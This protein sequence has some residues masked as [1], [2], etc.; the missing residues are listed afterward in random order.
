MNN[1][2]ISK[3]LALGFAVPGIAVIAFIF[4]SISQMDTINQQSTI[5]SN[6]WL[7]SVQLVERINTLTAELR[8]SEAVHI[9]SSEEQKIR[10]AADAIAELRKKISKTIAAY[11]KLVSTP[12]EQKLIAQFKR[13]YQA[14]LAIQQ[15]LLKLSENNKI[16]KIRPL[17][18]GKS[19]QAYQECSKTLLQL[20]KFN[21]KAAEKAST[22][23]DQVYT[24][25]MKIMVITLI[26]LAG[27]IFII[28]F[29]LSRYL[30]NTITTIQNAMTKMSAG[31]LTIRIQKKGKNELGMLA[32]YFN[33]TAEQ[34]SQLT[35]QLISVADNVSSSSD[36][37]AATMTQAD[38]NSQQ[39]LMQVEQVA[40]AVNEMSSTAVEIS[41]NATD[42]ESSVGE[43]CQ[44]VENGHKC[45]AQSDSIAGEISSSIKESAEIVNE[46]KNYSIEI[47]TVIDVITGISEQTNLLALNAAIEAARAGEQGRGFAVVADEVRSL[48]AKTQQSTVDIQEII[49]KLQ[50][51]AEIAD[52]YMHSNSEL[53]NQSQQIA[54]QVR[55]AFSGISQ[56]VT[57]ISEM[58]SLVATASTQQSSVTDEISSSIC[59]TVD[60]VNQNVHGISKSS[61]AS[62]ELSKESTEQKELLSYFTIGRHGNEIEKSEF[63]HK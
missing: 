11:T 2:S 61:N 36:T 25:A 37:L 9:L 7:P 33:K 40:T 55:E 35:H 41:Q 31:D 34:L 1:I 14:Y 46:L 62:V 10:E 6:N 21:E 29:I 3:L 49:A 45:L 20:S 32:E 59:T 26:A 38:S 44:N 28:A 18:L 48:A 51:Q 63:L 43:A 53:I 56:S 8:N 30:V 5:I 52:K 22:Y 19:L 24:R 15:E 13:E 54:Q 12:E 50:A 60:M 57:V 27:G 42:A 39:M 16:F 17:F 23:G 4:L 58:N 47:G